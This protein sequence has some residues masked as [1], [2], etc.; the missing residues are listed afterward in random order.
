MITFHGFPRISWKKVRPPEHIKTYIDIK[1]KREFSV[2]HSVDFDG[3]PTCNVIKMI[4]IL[5]IPAGG[6][7]CTE[8]HKDPK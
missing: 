6:S 1:M 2:V 3:H 8:E 7:G 5:D 4:F